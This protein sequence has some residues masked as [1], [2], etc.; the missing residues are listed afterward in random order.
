MKMSTVVEVSPDFHLCDSRSS[1]QLNAHL[2]LSLALSRAG[3]R[4]MA[5]GR[6]T[7]QIY[8]VCPAAF[9]PEQIQAAFVRCFASLFYTYRKFL[10]PSP[11]NQK[12]TGKTYRFNMEGFLR[13][14][15]RE[16]AQYM[17]V[18]RQTQ[19]KAGLAMFT[20]HGSILALATELTQP[21]SDA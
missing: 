20:L 11:V 16:N 2:S 3:C 6:C 8:L 9:H 10:H 13:S 19:G 1:W 15:P 21:L 5:H 12:A 4:L 14:M 18:L 17:Q 7:T